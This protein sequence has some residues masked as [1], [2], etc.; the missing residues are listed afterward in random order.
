MGKNESNSPDLIR[1]MHAAA[2]L[3]AG[4]GT[5]W[6]MSFVQYILRHDM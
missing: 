4:P 3:N 1:Q 2:G 5:P 6:C